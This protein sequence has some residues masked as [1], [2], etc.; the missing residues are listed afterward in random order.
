M[1][2]TI[3]RTGTSYLGPL[4]L[5]LLL[6][7][8]ILTAC[9][10]VPPPNPA[11]FSEPGWK[12]RQGQ[13]L[14]KSENALSEIAGELLVATHTN[15]QVYVS[16]SKTPVTLVTAQSSPGRWYIHYPPNGQW[17]GYGPAPSRVIWL[18]LAKFL[19]G[20]PPPSRWNWERRE[21]NGW[22]LENRGTG[23]YLEGFL[24]P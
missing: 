21:N 8:V 3:E 2:F 17:H 6:A 9:R 14:W 24:N 13:A 22:R 12:V 4:M 19:D 1:N 10:S 15:G 11:N 18:H 23:E 5:S 16:F 20:V 7:A